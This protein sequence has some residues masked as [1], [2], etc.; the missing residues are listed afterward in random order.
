LKDKIKE[1]EARQ[2]ASPEP[3]PEPEVET[4]MVGAFQEEKTGPRK[5]GGATGD[6]S[7]VLGL[8]PEMRAKLERE[9]RARAA[10]ARMKAL[11]GR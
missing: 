3:E 9:R 7:A 8:T 6:N 11:S 5:L 4:K 10:E 2:P 1:R